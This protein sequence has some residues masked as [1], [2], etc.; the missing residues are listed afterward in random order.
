MNGEP[1]SRRDVELEAM[2]REMDRVQ[3]ERLGHLETKIDEL[4]AWVRSELHNMD[5][6]YEEGWKRKERMLI[7]DAAHKAVKVAFGH[8]GVNVDD[9]GELE[10][11]RNDLRFGGV[12]RQAVSRSFLALIAAIFGGIGFSL[13]LTFKNQFGL[14]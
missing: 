9:P 6:R 8:L 3:Q 14:K 13:W 5:V 7:E 11:F 4:D 10:T 1:I 12:F 2:R